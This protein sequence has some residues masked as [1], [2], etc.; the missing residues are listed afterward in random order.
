LSEPENPEPLPRVVEELLREDDAFRL[1]IRAH[2]EIEQH[3]KLALQSR[4]LDQRMPDWLEHLGFARILSLAI[5]LGLVPADVKELIKPLTA[6]RNDFA[7]AGSPAELTPTRAKEVL[8]PCR[9]Y[10]SEEIKQLLK[11]E[12]P[13]TYLQISVAIIYLEF[14]EAIKVAVAEREFAE[15]AVAEARVRT[16]AKGALSVEQI[17]ELLADEGA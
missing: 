8:R 5:S 17:R 1:A 4:L 10:L 3:L 14:A 7:H 6:L 12:P 16:L 11:H 2:A 9:P 15:A 13:I